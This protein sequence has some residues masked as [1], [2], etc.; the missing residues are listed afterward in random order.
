MKK[1]LICLFCSIILLSTSG[2]GTNK[3]D[4][5]EKKVKGTVLY[6]YNIDDINYNE[7]NYK[8]YSIEYR[9]KV[10]DILTDFKNRFE[11][12]DN[13]D[14]QYYGSYEDIWGHTALSVDSNC[15]YEIVNNKITIKIES[16]K[17]IYS[18]SNYAKNNGYYN[19]DISYEYDIVNEGE[20]SETGKIMKMGKLDYHHVS[21]LHFLGLP[22]DEILIDSKSGKQYLTDGTPAGNRSPEYI[23]NNS[24]NL[25]KCTIINS[26]DIDKTTTN[27][28]NI[29]L[30]L[31][32]YKISIANMEDGTPRYYLII[33]ES[34]NLDNDIITIREIITTN[35]AVKVY[36]RFWG[37]PVDIIKV[38]AINY[39]NYEISNLDIDIF[40]LSSKVV[41]G[42]YGKYTFESNKEN[43]KIEIFNPVKN[44]A[45]YHEYQ[46]KKDY[47]MNSIDISKF[48]G[49]YQV[50]IISDFEIIDK[51]MT[52]YNSELYIANYYHSYEK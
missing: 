23:K 12:R 37:H 3:L 27:N 6:K 48:E 35:S 18:P 32:Q 14:C 50:S 21:Y 42:E 22:A 15:E 9:G 31:D 28:S 17:Q 8:A 45:F 49:K 7:D 26:K 33:T 2:C 4:Q 51:E 52:E 1:Q 24:L 29:R 40:N 20:L 34:D 47:L 36:F 11:F 10:D 5:P 44:K 38:G 39:G 30:P 46:I 19:Q 16:L 25:S 43:S 41:D 13:G